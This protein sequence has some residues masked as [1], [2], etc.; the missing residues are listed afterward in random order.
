MEGTAAVT[1]AAVRKWDQYFTWRPKKVYTQP[2]HQEFAIA[3][4]V[5]AKH[6]LASLLASL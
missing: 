5:R 6:L 3:R 4:L 1:L 2:F